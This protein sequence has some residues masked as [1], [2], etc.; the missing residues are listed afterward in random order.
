MNALHLILAIV[1]LSAATCLEFGQRCNRSP[2][3]CDPTKFLS[4]QEVGPGQLICQCEPADASESPFEPGICLKYGEALGDPCI[5]GAIQC[6]RLPNAICNETTNTC[7]CDADLDY[8]QH[9]DICLQYV[10]N[11]YDPC[12]L[13]TQQCAQLPGTLCHSF[14]STCTCDTS[15]FQ[16]PDQLI[17]VPYRDN[18]HQECL[19][20]TQQC[21]N[22]PGADCHKDLS[23]CEC[24]PPREYFEHETELRCLK[25][26]EVLY[27]PCEPFT[28]QCSYVFGALCSP[29]NQRAYVIQGIISK[30]QITQIALNIQKSYTRAAFHLLANA[31]IYSVPHVMTLWPRVSVRKQGMW[32]IPTSRCVSR[33]AIS[34]MTTVFQ[35]WTTAKTSQVL[36]AT[37]P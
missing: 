33:I 15:H 17:C 4:C 23:T 32:N 12:I 3:L 7:L 25:Y 26:A 18:L 28:E 6:S 21:K 1:F 22:I 16:H 19:P 31:G 30:I 9:A 14:N 8:F 10:R 29:A 11:L 36:T 35:T 20:E 24:L 2:D 5:P 37:S 27:E 13:G 34:S